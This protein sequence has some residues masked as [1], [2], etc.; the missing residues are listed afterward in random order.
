[1]ENES[2]LIERAVGG[3]KGALESLLVSVHDRVFLF[4]VAMLGTVHDAED[5][6]Q[7]ILIR[8]LTKLSSFN[9]IEF[10]ACK[11]N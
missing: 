1:M 11:C 10:S 7:E 2:L 4:G 9:L 3:D 8:V 6:T 5:M